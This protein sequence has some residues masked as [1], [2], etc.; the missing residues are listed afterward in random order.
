MEDGV[1]L[2]QK[3]SESD[4]GVFARIESDSSDVRKYSVWIQNGVAVHCTCPGFG[5]RRKCK[6][7]ARAEERACKWVFGFEGSVEQSLEQNVHMECP[8][9]GGKTVL[10]GGWAAGGV[11]SGGC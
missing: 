7:L 8:S 2:K 1:F 9:C 6:H 5:F 3:C 10:T 4:H 11:V